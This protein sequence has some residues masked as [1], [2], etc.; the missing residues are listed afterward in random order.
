MKIPDPGTAE[1]EAFVKRLQGGYTQE[2]LQAA[3][4]KVKNPEHWK[5]RINALLEPGEDMDVIDYAIRY[6]TGT[7]CWWNTRKD[8]KIRVRAP[9]YWAGPCN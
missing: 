8:G 7:E 6:F 5:A 1:M 9:G 2:E 4:D 3:F